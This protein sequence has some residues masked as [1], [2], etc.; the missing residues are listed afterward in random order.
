[1]QTMMVKRGSRYCKATPA[2]I[3]ESAGHYALEALNRARPTLES[4]T[5]VVSHLQRIYG[6][7]DYETFTVVFLDVRF[8]LMHCAEM[9]RGTLAE[10]SVHTREVAKECLWRGAAS[11]I[12]AH[13]HPSGEASPSNADRMV[14]ERL[15][16]ALALFDIRVADHL[17]IGSTGSWF[18]MAQ[19]GML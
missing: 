1:M 17:I 6:V 11:V 18:S 10:S 14:T 7:R 8:R 2:E 15:Q 19:S 13:N 4:P 16:R 5:D 9:F 12:L 3:A